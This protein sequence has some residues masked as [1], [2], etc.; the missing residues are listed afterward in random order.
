[1][2][3]PSYWGAGLWKGNSPKIVEA[4][5]TQGRDKYLTFTA[6]WGLDK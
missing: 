5:D 6:Y 4:R 3:N 2:R 1:L